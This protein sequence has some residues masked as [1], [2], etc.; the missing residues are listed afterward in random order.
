[1][2]IHRSFTMLKA[3]VPKRP[4][5][6]D[7]LRVTE[8]L[9]SAYINLSVDDREHVEGFLALQVYGNAGMG[10]YSAGRN[11]RR[12]ESVDEHATCQCGNVTFHGP[13]SEWARMITEANLWKSE[14]RDAVREMLGAL[15]SQKNKPRCNNSESREVAE[16]AL[17]WIQKDEY[18][19]AHLRLRNSPGYKELL[20]AAAFNVD[21]AEIR[22][23]YKA[24]FRK[25]SL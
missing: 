5:Y 16:K 9:V 8:N 23:R 15:I 14:R 3:A 7:R 17:E 4:K 21:R 24:L 13:W 6:F 20:T 1:M 22:K 12:A 11:H 19:S 25:A 18:N 2:Y 10:P